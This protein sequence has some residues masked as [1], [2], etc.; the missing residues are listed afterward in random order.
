MTRG[1][2]T[3][4]GVFFGARY[5]GLSSPEFSTAMS[6]RNGFVGWSRND[7]TGPAYRAKRPQ[8]VPFRSSRPRIRFGG[9]RPG[10]HPSIQGFRSDVGA[11]ANPLHHSSPTT[12][13]ILPMCLLLS[14][15]ACALSA[16]ARGKAE[17]ISGFTCCAKSGNACVR[18]VSAIPIFLANG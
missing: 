11:Q 13:T 4:S 17:S 9:R 8:L 1:R 6:L 18:N 12:R 2:L 10:V 16:R 14:I 5:S 7:R 15:R 3:S